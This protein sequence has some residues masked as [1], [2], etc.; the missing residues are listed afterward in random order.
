MTE[1]SAAPILG[2]LGNETRL[3]VFR[4]LVQ[5]G[6]EGLTIGQIQDH[7]GAAP[8]TM[9]HHLQTLMQ[10]GLVTQTKQGRSVICRA[11]YDTMNEVIGYLTQACCQG[12]TLNPNRQAG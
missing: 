7:L 9:A 3:Q 10:A 4:L 12:V 6:P 11:D 1:H 8:S 2:A 5:A